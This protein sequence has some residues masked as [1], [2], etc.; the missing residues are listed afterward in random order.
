MFLYKIWLSN[1][2][3]VGLVVKVAGL[4]SQ[5]PKF[6]PLCAIELTPGGVDSTR[7]P[8]EVGETSTSVLG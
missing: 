6:E 4:G 1:K 3:G 8:S 5:R 7:N 2:P